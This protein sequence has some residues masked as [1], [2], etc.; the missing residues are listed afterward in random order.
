MFAPERVARKSLEARPKARAER[1]GVEVVQIRE[2]RR[3]AERA[4]LSDA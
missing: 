3:A 4:H 1:F 2:K